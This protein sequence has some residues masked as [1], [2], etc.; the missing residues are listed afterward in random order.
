MAAAIFIESELK[1][2]D[3]KMHSLVA[4]LFLIHFK[5]STSHTHTKL[6]ATCGEEMFV[7]ALMRR[8][9]S[10]MFLKMLKRACRLIL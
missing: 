3:I 2:L 1:L 4:Q 5:L 9:Q 6:Q 8:F 7:K 10:V